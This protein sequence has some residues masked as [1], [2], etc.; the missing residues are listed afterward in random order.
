MEGR[1]T[2]FHF[3]RIGTV[4]V[5]V[6]LLLIG[7][8]LLIRN[9]LDFS[10]L[11]F[12]S[13]LWPIVLIILGIEY[14][15]K[16]RNDE[17]NGERRPFD[18]TAIVILF[19][20]LLI[21]GGLFSLK[22]GDWKD[23]LINISWNTTVEFEETYDGSDVQFISFAL[24][25]GDI[26]VVGEDTTEI[27]ISGVIKSR[28]KNEKKVLDIY[29]KE[30]KVIEGKNSFKYSVKPSPTFFSKDKHFIVD[31]KIVIP[32]NVK[33]EL[34]NTNGTLIGTNIDGDVTLK[35]TNGTINGKLIDGNVE[36]ES[37]N[38]TIKLKDVTGEASARTTNG[39]VK[40]ENVANHLIIKT[41]NGSITASSYVVG[42][43]WE[44]TTTNG[45]VKMTIP[46][47]ASVEI[48][49]ETTNG[50]V[51]G[52]FNWERRYDGHR[53][54]RQGSTILNEGKYQIDARST[55]GSIEINHE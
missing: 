35:T 49:G 20:I 31:L 4:T 55:N 45:K 47:S 43:D 12:L 37:T 39:N 44:M 22:D 3:K 30:R 2:M 7:L 52:N 42:G 29:E 40:V 28:V 46:S 34:T 33:L 13:Y 1:G 16:R 23:A 54:N 10:F 6:S 48:E 36:A 51:K 53:K 50:S 11:L 24:T 15:I 32:S 25:N 41:T 27:R 38:G 21:S 9:W 14:M 19:I 8:A 17:E 18:G 26:E 5:G